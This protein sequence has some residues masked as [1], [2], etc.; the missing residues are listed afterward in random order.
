M[1][2]RDVVPTARIVLQNSEPGFQQLQVEKLGW[3]HVKL[4]FA[5][6]WT[7]LN[8]INYIN[9]IIVFL[10][11]MFGSMLITLNQSLVLALLFVPR[12]C[13]YASMPRAWRKHSI[14]WWSYGDNWAYEAFVLSLFDSNSSYFP[15]CDNVFT[16]L[17][18]REGSNMIASVSRAQWFGIVGRFLR[19][20]QVVRK[21]G[22]PTPTVARPGS[23]WIPWP[24]LL[25]R[26]LHPLRC[27]ETVISKLSRWNRRQAFHADP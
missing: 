11:G 16:Y 2:R 7:I 27:D 19:V 24:E 13:F 3:S 14:A 25:E 15:R 20:R 6:N 22:C 26:D 10:C 17:E 1:L 4:V 18:R 8:A 12:L 9:R 23:A 5:A 21:V